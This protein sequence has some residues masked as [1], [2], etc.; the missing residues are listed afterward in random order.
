MARFIMGAL[1]FF[2]P[3]ASTGEDSPSGVHVRCGPAV[4]SFR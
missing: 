1:T 4:K 2:F 3:A